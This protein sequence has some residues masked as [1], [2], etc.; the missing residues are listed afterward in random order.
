METVVESATRRD[1]HGVRPGTVELFAH[2]VKKQAEM[3]ERIEA[4]L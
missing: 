4:E 1:E 3:L 2:L